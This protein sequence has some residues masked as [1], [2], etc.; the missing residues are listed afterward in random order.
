MRHIRPLGTAVVAALAL[1]ALIATDVIAA[2]PTKILPEPT[3]ASPISGVGHGN[4]G[5]LEL[6]NGEKVDCKSGSGEGTFTTPNAGIYTILYKECTGPLTTTCTGVGDALGTVGEEG[7]SHYVLA[8]ERLTSTTTTLV[9]ALALLVKQFHITC[10]KTGIELLV[11]LRGCAAGVVSPIGTLVA[12][13]T[14]KLQEFTK[15][16]P[17]ILEILLPE[18]TK[19]TKCPLEVSVA[20]SAT[21]EEF[22]LAAL[23]GEGT[24]GTFKKNGAQITVLL[25]N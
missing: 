2:E 1:G 24:A 23:T 14:R 8:L 15:G 16:E 20:E 21:G 11:L 7:E 12:Q 18:A 4:E 3:V 17:K 13:A 9:A 5:Q 10:G 25:M 6:V 19:E 22:T